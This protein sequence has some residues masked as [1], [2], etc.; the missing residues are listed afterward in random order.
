LSG[1]WDFA[2][3]ILA[4]G[5]S[6]PRQ[7][8]IAA[9][10]GHDVTCILG[11]SFGLG[12][13]IEQCGVREDRIDLRFLHCARHGHGMEARFLHFHRH[14]GFPEQAIRLQ[15]VANGTGKL[16]RRQTRSGN[17]SRNEREGDGNRWDSLGTCG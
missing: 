14:L 6:L 16:L 1:R 9:C 17:R 15:R 12:E 10:D 11:K 3:A 5:Q 8:E 13:N 4:A 7:G 2:P